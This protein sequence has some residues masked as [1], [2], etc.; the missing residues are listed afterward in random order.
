MEEDAGGLAELR[1]TFIL[2]EGIYQVSWLLGDRAERFCS[3]RWK[4]SAGRRGK[5]RQVQLRFPPGS[6]VPYNT[7]S[8]RAVGPQN[9]FAMALGG[10][11]DMKIN[12]Q[13]SFRAVGLDWF[14]TRL[15]NPVLQQDKN[16]DHIRVSTGLNFTFGAE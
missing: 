7:V 10:G 15:H 9:A 3:A 5:D 6:A 2:G 4:I 1:G 12:K 8:L 14:M 13:V 11:M 16:Q